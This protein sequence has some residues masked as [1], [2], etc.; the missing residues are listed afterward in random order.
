MTKAQCLSSTMDIYK[1]CWFQDKLRQ[2][3]SDIVCSVNDHLT[4]Y[5]NESILYINVQTMSIND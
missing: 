4:A 1:V 2:A 5:Q 3:N